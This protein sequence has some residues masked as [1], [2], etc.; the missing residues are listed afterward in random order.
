MPNVDSEVKYMSGAELDAIITAISEFDPDKVK[1]ASLK[2]LEAKE[3]MADIKA[4]LKS[5]LLSWIPFIADNFLNLYFT[6]TNPLNTI[7]NSNNSFITL[8]FFIPN[9]S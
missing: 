1:D 5:L 4:P 8:F 6:S 3:L 9:N 7:P 2:A